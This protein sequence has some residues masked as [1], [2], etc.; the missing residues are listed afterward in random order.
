[1]TIGPVIAGVYMQTHKIL[2]NSNTISG[3]ALSSFPS[4]E[5]Y[6]LIFLT[7]VLLSVLFI[8]FSMLSK[9]RAV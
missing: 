3:S 4:A 9:K 1:M 2:L 6:N 8:V 5:A 7:G